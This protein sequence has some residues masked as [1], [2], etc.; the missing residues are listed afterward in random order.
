M[1][2]HD[3]PEKTAQCLSTSGWLRTGDLAHYDDDGYFYITDRV[4]ELIKVRGFPVAPAELEA[5]LL[6]HPAVADAAV[7]RVPVDESGELPRAHV[8][9][10]AD[11]ESQKTTDE[12]VSRFVEENV[13]AYKRLKGGATFV[14]AVPKS[15]SGTILRRLLRD[16]AAA[17]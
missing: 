13:A 8:F 16:M 14:D 3:V 5:L 15:A 11:E 12:D 4:K 7:I 10:K 17:E 6:T 1:G 2:L 9:I